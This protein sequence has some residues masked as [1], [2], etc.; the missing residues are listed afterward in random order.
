MDIF[1]HNRHSLGMNSAEVGV[2][3]EASEIGLRG[4]LECQDGVGLES[5]IRL[6]IPSN[7]TNQFLE[8]QF[9][10]EEIG[11]LLITANLAKGSDSGSVAMGLLGSTSSRCWPASGL[12]GQVPA[13][14]LTTSG[15][16]CG[17]LSACHLCWGF[18][19]RQMVSG[20]YID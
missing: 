13:R 10:D 19:K 12:S 3:E 15:S 8:R 1:G 7:L 6:V 9:L 20:L 11:R 2:L 17:L 4:F 18:A 16:A 5:E 14:R